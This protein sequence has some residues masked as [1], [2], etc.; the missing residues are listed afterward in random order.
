MHTFR[1]TPRI[2]STA[3]ISVLAGGLAAPAP[4]GGDTVPE[5]GTV[6]SWI[7]TFD[8]PPT[9]QQLDVLRGLTPSVTGFTALPAAVVN[10]PEVDVPLLRA[11]PGVRGVWPN[12]TYQPLMSAATRTSR[13]AQVWE[14]LGVTGA[15]VGIAVIDAGVDGAHPDL[16]A[17]EVFCKGTPVKT[18]Q[19]VK[20]LGRQT[21]LQEPVV[22]LEDQISTDSSSGH[23]SHVAGIAAGAGTASAEAGTYRGVAH[24]AHLVGYGVGEAVEAVNVLAAYEHAIRHRDEYGIR[25]INNSWGPGAFT[26]YDPEHPVNRATDA[27]WAAGINVVFGAGNDGTRTDSLNM[28][29]AHPRAISAGGGRKDGHQAFFS[30]RGVP[31]SPLWRPTVTAPGENIASVRAT[32]GFTVWAADAGAGSANPDA[33]TGDDALWY[34]T[35]SG[36]SMAAPHVSGVIA[37]V[38]EAAI[39]A[40]GT[41]LTPEQ[42]RNVLQNTARPMA[43]QYQHWSVGAGYVDAYAAVQAAAAGTHLGPY[44]DGTTYDVRPFSGTVGPAALLPTTSFSANH[45]VLPGAT[46]LDVMAD[47]GPERVLAAN[48][49]VDI[50]LYRPDGTL[51]R[52][53]FLMCDP[54]AQPNGYSSFCSSAPNERLSVV[55]PQAGTWRVVVRG[56]SL[57]ATEDVRGLWSVAYPDGTPAPAAAAPATVAVSGAS[58]ASVVGQSATVTATVRDPSGAPVPGAEV[59]WASTGVGVVAGAETTTDSR[60]R[61]TA[62]LASGAPGV[63]TVTATAATAAAGSTSVTWLGLSP[64]CLLCPPPSRPAEVSGGGWW[65]QGGGKRHL[66]VSAVATATEVSGGFRYDAKD[67]TVVRN[68]DVEQLTVSGGTATLVGDATVSGATGYRYRL[69]I[70]DGHTD[71]V[72]L[73]VTA[74]LD[75]LYRLESAGTL[76]GGN[77]TVRTS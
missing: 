65:S 51:F 20:V 22:V 11:L 2:V 29:S 42:V 53:T 55:A 37:L 54:A 59:S 57:T 44:D 17:A 56:G 9:A 52:S 25:V 61:A 31:G 26:D 39:G 48:Q 49:D 74:P 50:E 62:R 34:A 13:A 27:A 45:Q 66:S 41:A 70:T 71:S 43:P 40:R 77:L 12:E 63:Q 28:F 4:A 8:A 46:S 68:A 36:T 6:A 58:P 64:P 14:E 69:T 15:G 5:D 3:L 38:Q 1:L 75:P 23:G 32:T 35:S 60:G 72:D 47:W 16:C 33:P 7:V 24:G 10:V 21:V 18:V 76:G 73:V 30:S 67:G 19:N